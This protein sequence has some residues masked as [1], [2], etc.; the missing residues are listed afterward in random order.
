MELMKKLETE[1]LSL[2]ITDCSVIGCSSSPRKLLESMLEDKSVLVLGADLR[3]ASVAS[4]SLT[5]F[6]NIALAPAA[7]KTPEA[8]SSA[9]T[10]DDNLSGSILRDF[11]FSL[12]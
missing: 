5:T 12:S 2:P 11:I 4:D 7:V 3:N 6:C 1:A 10:L 8:L 9:F